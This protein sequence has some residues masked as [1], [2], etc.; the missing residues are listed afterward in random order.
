M[1]STNY[2]NTFIEV[3]EDCPAT[4][5]EIPPLKDNKKSVAN[6]QFEMLHEHPYK[7]T[8]DDILFAV[9]ATRKEIPEEELAEQRALF[10]SKGQPCFRASPL[11]KRYGWGIHSNEEGKIAMFSVELEAY[12]KFIADDS[13]VKKK[14][15][16]SKRA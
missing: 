1:S 15:M 10:F 2:F 14:A 12:Q 16:R 6:L 8:S 11:T 9:F 7:F 5:G 4:K 13:I 3:A